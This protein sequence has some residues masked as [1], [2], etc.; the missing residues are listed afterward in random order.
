[1]NQLKSQLKELDHERQ[2]LSLYSKREMDNDT[3]STIIS[4]INSL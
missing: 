3:T 1:M 4:I 2:M